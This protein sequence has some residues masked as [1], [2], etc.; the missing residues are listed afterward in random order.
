M[1]C[2]E[3][4]D[5]HRTFSSKYF[6]VDIS[7]GEFCPYKGGINIH[8]IT[9]KAKCQDDKSLTGELEL[10]WQPKK[11]YSAWLAQSYKRLGM[12]SKFL[13]VSDCA[14]LLEFRKPVPMVDAPI[15]PREQR[16]ATS[17]GW[18]LQYANFCRDRLCPMCQ[19][20]KSLKVFSQ[21]SR[22]MDA[23]EN[24]FAFLFLTLTVPN[25]DGKELSKT[26][27][28]MQKAFGKL[29]HY[30]KFQVAV[31]G[32]F[33]ALEVTRNKITGLYHP[34][35][36]VILAVDLDYFTSDK[37]IDQS[38]PYFEWTKLWEKA[39]KNLVEMRIPP[40]V[41][42]KRVMPKEHKDGET[43]VKSIKSAVA[44]VSKYSVKSSEYINSEDEKTRDEIIYTLSSSLAGRRLCSF[45]GVFEDVRKALDLD[46]FEEGD[47]IHI[48]GTEMRSDV[49]YM[50]RRYNWSCG[51]FKLLDECI[52]RNND[53]YEVM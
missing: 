23:I 5:R 29:R 24:D 18:K 51:A 52:E 13:A 43:A 30:K 42:V 44:E 19:W 33:K 26:I 41:H 10:K 34:H 3:F 22:V 12:R 11:E 39:L 1:L 45:G 53:V 48:D 27:D 32:Y 36:H 6:P 14:S 7:S 50:I 28:K 38:A 25:C 2:A 9:K 8:C 21:V 37:Y 15:A 17:D 20:R 40:I 47:L 31:C 35:F 4:G 16:G 46:D 49:A